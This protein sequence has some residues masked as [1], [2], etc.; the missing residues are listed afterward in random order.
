MLIS[1]DRFNEDILLA[2]LRKFSK[3]KTKVLFVIG[4]S[5]DGYLDLATGGIETY[6]E[7]V[8]TLEWVLEA[9]KQ[10]GSSKEEPH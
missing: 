9:V 6:E 5:E 10:K 4:K 1:I 3:N 7:I 8:G 2:A